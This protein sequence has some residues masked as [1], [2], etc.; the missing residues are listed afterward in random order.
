MG[1]LPEALRNYLL[2]LGWGH[3]DDEIIS[4]AQAIEWFD[5]GGVGRAAAR[6]DFSKLESLNGHYIRETDDAQL[7]ELVAAR[8]AAAPALTVDAEAKCRG[9]AG[10]A[11]RKPRAK[12]LVE[13]ADHARFYVAPGPL[14]LE[15]KAE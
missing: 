4:T 14:P 9:R 12:T 13:L 5:L 15:P 2:R 3:G 6:F 8:L 10:M 7:A 1:Y 11:G